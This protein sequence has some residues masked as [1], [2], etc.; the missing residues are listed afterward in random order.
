MKLLSVY[1]AILDYASMAA[2]SQGYVKNAHGD[3]RESIL[4]E[5]KQLVLPL[6]EQLRNFDS[7][8]KIIFHP[9]AENI[10]KGES[11]IIQ[12]LKK[13]ICIKLN[14]S[15][16]AIIQALI[17]I[18]ASPDLHGRMNPQQAELFSVN[19]DADVKTLTNFVKIMTVGIKTKPESAFVSMYLNRGGVYRGSKHSKVS[20]MTFP[21]YEQLT[22]EA[23]V[24]NGISLEHLRIKDKDCITKLFQFIFPGLEMPEQYNYGADTTIAPFLDAL[25]MGSARVASKIN[26]IVEL[27]KDY[28]DDAESVMFTSE[29]LD[30]I[31]NMDNLKNDIRRIPIQQTMDGSVVVEP[32]EEIKPVTTVQMPVQNTP[33]SQPVVQ[34]SNTSKGKV[35]FDEAVQNNQMAAPVY[36]AMQNNQFAQNQIQ[37]N[38]PPVAY[39]QLGQPV[40][41]FGQ[42]VMP[43]VAYQPQPMMQQIPLD[44]YGRPLQPPAYSMNNPQQFNQPQGWPQPA[45]T[46]RPMH[47][48]QSNQYY[49]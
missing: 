16:A 41:Q 43:Q 14:I 17:N 28:I 38:Y 22:K 27:Y 44:P 48:M 21:L 30:D 45:V 35:S 7:K 12:L 46:G 9:M 26:D 2:D 36:N 31:V 8:Q 13:R 18:V 47:M 23:K 5:G 37:Q 20:V 40:N 25:M 29:W 34:K 42:V 3:S 11:E 10:F 32:V 15:T 1:R 39:N 49:R 4:I 19:M 6:P 24:P 33:V